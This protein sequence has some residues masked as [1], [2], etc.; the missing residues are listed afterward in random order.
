VFI[1]GFIFIKEGRRQRAGGRG[2]EENCPLFP[3]VTKGNKGLR[4]PPN[5]QF[6][7]SFSGGVGIL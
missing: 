5:F 1:C 4:P 2:Q 3:E 7:G 6:G